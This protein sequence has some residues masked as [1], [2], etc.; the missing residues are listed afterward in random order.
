M[1][2]VTD[3]YFRIPSDM[4]AR[5]YFELSFPHCLT[6]ISVQVCCDVRDVRPAGQTRPGGCTAPSQVHR[7]GGIRS[8]S[9]LHSIN[10][11]NCVTV[12]G[13][14]RKGKMMGRVELLIQTVETQEYT[15]VPGFLSSRPN[16]L[17][18]PPPHPQASFA[19]PP[20]TL[21]CGRGGWGS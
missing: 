2:F 5:K 11:I 7:K 6:L 18:P 3:V 1:Q 16:W 8:M 14:D 17:S 15:R 10:F 21:A 9:S 4:G 13:K 12:T 19:P 20:H